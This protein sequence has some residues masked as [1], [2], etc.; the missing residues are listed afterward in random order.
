LAEMADLEFGSTPLPHLWR[1]GNSDTSQMQAI[2]FMRERNAWAGSADQS[3]AHE[4]FVE[5]GN[6][7][8]VEEGNWLETNLLIKLFGRIIEV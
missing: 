4:N 3:L 2:A 6:E 1:G 5:A 7:E 8:I